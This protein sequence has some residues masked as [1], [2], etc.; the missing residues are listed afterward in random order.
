MEFPWQEGGQWYLL[1][2][3]PLTTRQGLERFMVRF[4]AYLTDIHGVGLT[5]GGIEVAHTLL[6]PPY[7]VGDL[8]EFLVSEIGEASR[9][10]E[11]LARLGGSDRE[12]RRA[13]GAH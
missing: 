7:A 4:D 8:E 13:A 10:V 12:H 6:D 2:L 11:A 1:M 3:M 5:K 9:I